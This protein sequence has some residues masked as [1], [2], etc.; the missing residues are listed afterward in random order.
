MKQGD[1][2]IVHLDPV[3]GHE[4]AKTRP[5]IVLQSDF[6]NIYLS[7]VIVAPLSSHVP[8]KLYPTM[9]LIDG[10][11]LQKKSVLKLEQMRCVDKSRLQNKIG[12]YSDVHKINEIVDIIFNF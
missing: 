5:C 2:F 9:L 12:H 4:Q 7:T 6:L 10:Y 1:I 8:K 11:G 3:V